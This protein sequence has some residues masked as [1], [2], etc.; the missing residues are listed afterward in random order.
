MSPFFGSPQFI[1]ALNDDRVRRL[2]Q[3]SRTRRDGTR[4]ES[5]RRDR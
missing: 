1:A 3:H 4:V 2:R 5:R